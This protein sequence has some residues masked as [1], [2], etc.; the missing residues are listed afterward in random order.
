MCGLV[1]RP[2]GRFPKGVGSNPAT[3]DFY[4]Y[5]FFNLHRKIGENMELKIFYNL[6]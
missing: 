5:L 1:A 2:N 6:K 4:I 3:F